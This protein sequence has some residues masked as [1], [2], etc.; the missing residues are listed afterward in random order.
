MGRA[1]AEGQIDLTPD[2]IA[3]EENCLLCEACT[4]ICPAGFRME[5]MGLAIRHTIHQGQ[6]GS[7]RRRTL[8]ALA[9]RGPLAHMWLLRLSSRATWLY[10]RSGLQWLLRRSR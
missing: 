9:F 5:D 3:H 8:M 2:I 1:L 7:R 10:Q 6:T 4:A